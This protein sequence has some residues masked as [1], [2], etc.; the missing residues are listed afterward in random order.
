MSLSH[1]IGG[2]AI[3]AIALSLSAISQSRTQRAGA[4]AQDGSRAIL[5]G[6]SGGTTTSGISGS[7]AK[8]TIGGEGGRGGAKPSGACTANSKAADTAGLDCG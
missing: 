7:P 5:V 4:Q 2:A 1:V 3:V 6:T 8:V